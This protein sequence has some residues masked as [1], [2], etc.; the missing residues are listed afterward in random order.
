V[1]RSSPSRKSCRPKTLIGTRWRGGLRRR[2]VARDNLDGA[3]SG[4]RICPILHPAMLLAF[5]NGAGL[6]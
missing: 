6:Q 1:P 5:T 2:Y 3:V 4:M